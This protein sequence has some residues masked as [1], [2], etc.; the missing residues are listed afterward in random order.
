[1]SRANT[2]WFANYAVPWQTP[3]KCPFRNKEVSFA[4]FSF[5]SKPSP[6]P[7]C[8][9]RRYEFATGWVQRVFPGAK[10]LLSI[11]TQ[12]ELL[13]NSNLQFGRCSRTG[14][15]QD[16]V[17][18]CVSRTSLCWYVWNKIRKIH[19]FVVECTKHHDTFRM[20]AKCSLLTKI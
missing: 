20:L 1:M 7:V 9:A 12:H 13:H 16:A 8:R 10:I 19:S 18:G 2:F 4:L 6:A 5:W 14:L 3:L 11:G 17:G 15:P